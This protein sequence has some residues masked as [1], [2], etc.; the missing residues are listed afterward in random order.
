MQE[1]VNFKNPDNEEASNRAAVEADKKGQKKRGVGILIGC[2]V[3]LILALLAAAGTMFFLSRN[4]IKESG[5]R[6]TREVELPSFSGI[7]AGGAMDIDIKCGE[8]QKVEITADKNLIPY[9]KTEVEDGVL[10]IKPEK[11]LHRNNRITIS[12]SVPD[13]KSL[14]L[15]GASDVKIKN[16][17]ND[18]LNIDISGAVN[19][20]ASGETKNLKVDASGSS[21]IDMKK[22]TARSVKIDLSGSSDAKVNAV[23]ELDVS[24]TGTGIVTYWGN[25]E[26]I[27][28]EISGSGS[29]KKAD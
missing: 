18:L 14:S 27:N 5:I 6:E 10:V 19:V 29:L 7:D 26:K 23:K 2:A 22:L 28:Q 15:S 3:V 25:P 16:V 11:C 1:D 17:K 21:D 12:I 4:Y 13:I 20:S 8:E 24:I 9:I